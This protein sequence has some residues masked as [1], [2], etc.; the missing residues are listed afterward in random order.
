[1]ILMKVAFTG[2]TGLLPKMAILWK[3]RRAL[4]FTIVANRSPTAQTALV[5]ARAASLAPRVVIDAR[6]ARF[7][8]AR[9]LV[10]YARAARLVRRVVIYAGRTCRTHRALR[11]LLRAPRRALR[12]R[13]RLLQVLMWGRLQLVAVC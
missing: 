6:A 5:H 10:V 4:L 8:L 1:M 11:A 12:T 3:T 7:A 13:F 9:R 2:D